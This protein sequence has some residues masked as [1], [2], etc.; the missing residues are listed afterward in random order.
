MQEVFDIRAFGTKRRN[1]IRPTDPVA[2]GT[3]LKV[4]VED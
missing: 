3:L 1:A 2:M 4:K